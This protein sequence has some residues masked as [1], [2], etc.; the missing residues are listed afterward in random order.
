M[1]PVF[2]VPDVSLPVT[3]E[4]FVPSVRSILEVLRKQSSS[5]LFGFVEKS[6]VPCIGLTLRVCDIG[7]AGAAISLAGCQPH[8]G[9]KLIFLLLAME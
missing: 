4:G 8:S 7:A 2:A 6:Q 9:L 5:V 3:G 1:E